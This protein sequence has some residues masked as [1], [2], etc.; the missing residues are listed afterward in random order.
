M[1]I[2][3]LLKHEKRFFLELNTKKILNEIILNK[4]KKKKRKL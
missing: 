2:I 4:I 1:I 3:I